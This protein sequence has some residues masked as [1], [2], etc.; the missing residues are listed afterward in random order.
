MVALGVVILLIA[1]FNRDIISLITYGY[2]LGVGGLLVP[3]FACY[4][5]KRATSAGCISA[6]LVGGV[7]YVALSSL[8]TWPAL[9]VSLPA[10]LVTM[11]IVSL[12]TKAP[13]PKCYDLY[14]D[15]EWAKT[16]A[17]DVE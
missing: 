1:M 5:W 4:F 17:T 8:V 15:D 2:S 9:F 10:S 3:F 11:V 7:T 16:H 13:D 12:S 14:F 6:M